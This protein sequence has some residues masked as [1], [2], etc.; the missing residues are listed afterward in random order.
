MFCYFFYMTNK[1]TSR[2]KIKSLSA[3]A[4]AVF[5]GL[6]SGGFFERYVFSVGIQKSFSAAEARNLIGKRVK[7]VCQPKANLERK[8]EIIGYS[9]YGFGDIF[10][11]VIW[12]DADKKSQA[13][14]GK[15]CFEQCVK[16]AAQE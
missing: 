11:N 16:L 14:Y 9:E 5:I 10:V 15:G 3:F 6:W 13:G 4:F 1:I 12:E 7:D 8:G 2:L